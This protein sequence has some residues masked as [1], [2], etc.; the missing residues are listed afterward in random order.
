MRAV[1]D[2]KRYWAGVIAA[3]AC[4]V[5]TAFVPPVATYAL[6][7]VAIGFVLESATAWWGRN[8]RRGGMHDYRQ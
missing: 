7:M 8:A 3:V 5:A 4:F 6:T 2:T 1:I